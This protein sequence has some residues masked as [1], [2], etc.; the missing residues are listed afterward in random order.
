ML[1]SMAVGSPWSPCPSFLLPLLHRTALACTPL[2]HHITLTCSQATQH[3]QDML[4]LKGEEPMWLAHHVF[5]IPF[6]P[7]AA[8][9]RGQGYRARCKTKD[10]PG[11]PPGSWRAL[12]CCRVMPPHR[13]ASPAPSSPMPGAGPTWSTVPAGHGAGLLPRLCHQGFS[14]RPTARSSTRRG[15]EVLPHLGIGLHALTDRRRAL[16]QTPDTVTAL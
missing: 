16:P 15:H 12:Q 6:K 7:G 10:P 2:H 4:L 8:L 9:Q 1:P 14:M 13:K 3:G 5:S 11:S